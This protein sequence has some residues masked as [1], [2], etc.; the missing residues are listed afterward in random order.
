M[1]LN[2]RY[3]LASTAA[4]AVLGLIPAAAAQDTIK[5]GEINSYSGMPGFTQPYKKAW[6]A[7]SSR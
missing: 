3:L 5:I 1:T 7:R 4:A 6:S 2:R